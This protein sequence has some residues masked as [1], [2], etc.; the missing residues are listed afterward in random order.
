MAQSK[1][2]P[3]GVDLDPTNGIIATIGTIAIPETIIREGSF[4][5]YYT[6]QHPN[7]GKISETPWGEPFWEFIDENRHSKEYRIE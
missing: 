4:A 2:K 5:L 6:F 7:V 1:Y 3:F